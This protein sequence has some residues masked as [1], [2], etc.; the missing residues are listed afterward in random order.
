MCLLTICM[1]SSENVYSA[2][3]PIFFNWDFLLLLLL[4]CMISLYI[5][6]MN[7]LLAVWFAQ[8]FSHPVG[9]LLVLLM[10]P[11]AVQEIFSLIWFN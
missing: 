4:S 9:C 2:P 6:Y 8:I 10:V 1:S 5:L 7:L 11:F 3:L